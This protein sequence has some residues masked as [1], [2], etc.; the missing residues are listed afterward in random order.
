MKRINSQGDDTQTGGVKQVSK[1]VHV[2]KVA[3][4]DPESGKATK[5]I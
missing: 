3:L 4:I 1:S 2:S 5:V